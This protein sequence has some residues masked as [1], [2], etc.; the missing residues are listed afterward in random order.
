MGLY[1][2]IEINMGLDCNQVTYDASE[3]NALCGFMF[4]QV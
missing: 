3:D 1:Y 2:N 4:L